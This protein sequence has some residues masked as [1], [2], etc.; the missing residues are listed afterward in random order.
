MPG[1]NTMIHREVHRRDIQSEKYAKSD[2][3]TQGLKYKHYMATEQVYQQQ[4]QQQLMQQAQMA[5][6]QKGAPA[7]QKPSM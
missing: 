6:V 3:K 7:P 5:M 4:Q 2:E 1:E